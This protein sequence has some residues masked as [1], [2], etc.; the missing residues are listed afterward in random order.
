MSSESD[1][2]HQKLVALLSWERRKRYEQILLALLCYALLG[3]LLTLP[4]HGFLQ[5]AINRWLMPTLLFGLMAPFFLVRGRWR[6]SDS[7]RALAYVDKTLRLD[8]RVLT[9][10]E[11]LERKETRAA[12][13]LVVQQARDK[14]ADLNPKALFRRTWSWQ[15]YCA[16]PIFLVWFGLLWF[17]IG[18][19]FDSGLQLSA[20]QTV[21]QRVREFARE[22][23]EKAKNQGLGESLRLGRELE[24]V[25]Q[26]GINAQSGDEKFKAELAAME[27]KIA[28]MAKSASE[29]PTLSAAES[30][31]DL[32]DLKA[33]L[34]AARDLMNLADPTK[35]ASEVGSQWLDQLASLP[36]LKQQ[37]Q[38][39]GRAAESFARDDLKS[40]LDRLEK[41]ATAELDRRT[42]LDAQQFLDQ[43][44]KQ[45]QGEKGDSEA[46]LAGQE[47][48]D[49]PTDGERTSNNNN[50]P[51]KEPGK[52]E[53]ESQP[54]PQFEPGPSAHVKGLLGE[55][56]SSGLLFKAKPT[57]GKS[58]VSQDDVITSYRRQ[59]EVEL[60]TE[61][62]PEELK[63][64]I[65]NY[66]L[67]LGM[68][69][70]AK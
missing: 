51:G 24:Q 6:R 60:N 30:Q 58:K 37:L 29:Q 13:L 20:A 49:A 7:V 50:S 32:R 57:P 27:N 43:V 1:C 14:L 61:R 62:V 64:T 2:L 70:T 66:F 44:M 8:E 11:L 65:R 4:F 16:L 55:G 5:N 26:K 41:Q 18:L 35:Q 46:R 40:F 69:E 17:D 52:K 3:A 33:E 39:E 34:E 48:R 15:A 31:Q 21:A 53:A 9:A 10:W 28:T 68:R 56:G 22:L 23:Q 59:A 47:E 42:L 54:L 63:E 38:Q 19:R 36:Q 45:G 25:A 67:S 12:A